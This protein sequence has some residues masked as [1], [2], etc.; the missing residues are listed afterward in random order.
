MGD[1]VVD[2][3]MGLPDEFARQV[4]AFGEWADGYIDEVNAFRSSWGFPVLPIPRLSSVFRLLIGDYPKADEKKSAELGEAWAEEAERAVEFLRDAQLALEAVT[5]SWNGGVAAPSLGMAFTDLAQAVNDYATTASSYAKGAYDFNTTVVMAKNVFQISLLILCYELIRAA[6]AVV[7]TMGGSLLTVPPAIVAARNGTRVAV[8]QALQRVS[9]IFIQQTLRRLGLRSGTVATQLGARTFAGAAARAAPQRVGGLLTNTVARQQSREVL[10]EVVAR[11]A[12]R[13]ATPA[14]RRQAVREVLSNPAVRQAIRQQLAAKLAGRSV[15]F[16]SAVTREHADLITAAVRRTAERRGAH[17]FTTGNLLRQRVI[18]YGLQSALKFGVGADVYAQLKTMAETD[19]RYEFDLRSTA[20]AFVGASLGGAPLGLASR[21]PAFVVLGAAGG[22]AGYAGAAAVIHA[23]EVWDT[24]T[25]PGKLRDAVTN[26]DQLWKNDGIRQQIADAALGGAVG[27]SWERFIGERSWHEAGQGLAVRDVI[28]TGQAPDLG[29]F[30]GSG[31]APAIAQLGQEPVAGATPEAG[32]AE[33][34]AGGT[35][36]GG[37]AAGAA[38]QS[39]AASGGPGQGGASG[40]GGSNTG[41]GGGARTGGGAAG[42]GGSGG[43]SGNGRSGTAAP[44]DDGGNEQNPESGKPKAGAQEQGEQARTS[45]QE[46]EQGR[47]AQQE[48]EQRRVSEQETR[49]GEQETEQGRTGD[50][51]ERGRTGA[52]EAEQVGNQEAERSGHQEGQ[53]SGDRGAEETGG[54]ERAAAE[55]GQ[56]G[57]ESTAEN[58]EAGR[59]ESEAR[60]PEAANNSAGQ[61]EGANQP[62]APEPTAGNADPSSTE[63]AEANGDGT[64]D[65]SG[66]TSS[67]AGRTAPDESGRSDGLRELG[68][69][70]QSEPLRLEPPSPPEDPI[71][72]PDLARAGVSDHLFDLIQ[73]GLG[74]LDVDAGIFTA[75]ATTGEVVQVRLGLHDDLPAG[76][77]RVLPGEFELTPAGHVQT[78]PA[79]IRISTTTTQY[80]AT[81]GE[82]GRHQ[83]A[84]AL[85]HLL[86]TT[87]VIASG[88]FTAAHGRTPLPAGETD[89]RAFVQPPPRTVRTAPG[90]PGTAQQSEQLLHEEIARRQ[91]ETTITIADSDPIAIA[92]TPGQTLLVHYAQAG[93]DVAVDLT[94]DPTLAPGEVQARAP[95]WRNDD[96]ST[97]RQ[98]GPGEVR[99]STAATPEQMRSMVEA[100]LRA[101]HQDVPVRDHN[102]RDDTPSDVALA[103]SAVVDEALPGM[104]EVARWL[105]DQG[106]RELTQDEL[107]QRLLAVFPGL[108]NANGQQLE[109][110]GALFSVGLTFGGAEHVAT[111]AVLGRR[112]TALVGLPE[113]SS[114]GSRSTTTS[115]KGKAPLGDLATG[116][117]FSATPQTTWSSTNSRG[118]A[119]AQQAHVSPTDQLRGEFLRYDLT[120]VKLWIRAEAGAATEV[121]AD[122]AVSIWVNAAHQRPAGDTVVFEGARRDEDELVRSSRLLDLDDAAQVVDAV[123]AQLPARIRDSDFVRAQVVDQVQR[124]AEAALRPD[125]LRFDVVAKPGGRAHQVTLR[126]RVQWDTAEPAHAAAAELGHGRVVAAYHSATG[127]TSLSRTSQ[128]GSSVGP[129]ILAAYEYLRGRGVSVGSDTGTG[130]FMLLDDHDFRPKHTYRVQVTTE[131]EVGRRAESVTGRGF[132]QLSVQ[133]AASNGL[134][135]GRRE[136]QYAEDGEIATTT[137]QELVVD[138]RGNAVTA[139]REVPLVARSGFT[140]PDVPGRPDRSQLQDSGPTL[141]DRVVRMTGLPAVR[142]FL[143]SALTAGKFTGVEAVLAQLTE[144]D[145]QAWIGEAMQDGFLIRVEPRNGD[146][147]WV[148]VEARWAPERAEEIGRIDRTQR[149]SSLL[150]STSHSSSVELTRSR[151]H[152]VTGLLGSGLGAN[153]SPSRSASSAFSQSENVGTRLE[154]RGGN[155]VWRLPVALAVSVVD[156]TGAPVLDAAGAPVRA[157]IADQVVEISVPTAVAVAGPT[158]PVVDP[159]QFAELVTSMHSLLHLDARGLDAA[160]RSAMPVTGAYVDTTNASAL[161]HIGEWLSHGELVRPHAPDGDVRGRAEITARPTGLRVLNRLTKVAAGP[162]ALSQAGHSFSA[163]RSRSGTGSS[164]DSSSVAE[165]DLGVGTSQDRTTATTA[166]QKRAGGSDENVITPYHDGLTFEADLDIAV[167]AGEAAGKQAPTTGTAVVPGRFQFVLSAQQVVEFYANGNE[168]VVDAVP[169]ATIDEMLTAWADDALPLDRRIAARAVLHRAAETGEINRR[170]VD[171]ALREYPSAMTRML[172]R[173]NEDALAELKRS[174]SRTDEELVLNYRFRPPGYQPGSG[175]GPGVVSGWQT[176]VPPL[177]QAMDLLAQLDVTDTAGLEER[178]R[179]ALAPGEALNHT[180][181]KA[182]VDGGTDLFSDLIRRN[183]RWMRLTVTYEVAPDGRATATGTEP[184]ATSSMGHR[185]RAGDSATSSTTNTGGRSQNL[186]ADHG[187]AEGDVGGTGTTNRGLSRTSSATSSHAEVSEPG[188]V[189]SSGLVRFERPARGRFTVKL[190]TAPLG[191]IGVV[192]ALLPGQ[193]QVASSESTGTL[194]FKYAMHRARPEAHGPR[195][196]ADHG[197]L[198]RL[199]DKVTSR[200]V[201]WS[202]HDLLPSAEAA[203]RKVLRAAWQRP[204][205]LPA[206]NNLTHAIQRD[207]TAQR[208]KALWH[209]LSSGLPTLVGTYPASPLHNVAVDVRLQNFEM[210]VV[211]RYERGE[212]GTYGLDRAQRTTSQSRGRSRTDSAGVVGDLPGD[213]IDGEV[214]LTPGVKRG[215]T[216]SGSAAEQSGAWAQSEA[217]DV[218]PHAL[219]RLRARFTVT[220]TLNERTDPALPVV[221]RHA[222]IDADPVDL[223]VEVPAEQLDALQNALRNEKAWQLTQDAQL[224]EGKLKGVLRALTRRNQAAEEQA[225]DLNAAMRAAEQRP[226]HDP[227]NPHRSLAAHV[228]EEHAE[229]TSPGAKLRLTDDATAAQ[230][231][232]DQ[233]TVERMHGFLDEISQAAPTVDVQP[234]RDVVAGLER[235]AAAVPPARAAVQQDPEARS[236]FENAVQNWRN[237]RQDLRAMLVQHEATGAERTWMARFDPGTPA[238]AG[239]LATILET[240]A[241]LTGRPWTLPAELDL[242]PLDPVELARGLAAELS[243]AETAAVEIELSVVGTDG[244][245]TGFR[246]T[247]DGGVHSISEPPPPPGPPPAPRWPTAPPRPSVPPQPEEPEEEPDEAEQRLAELGIA[248]HPDDGSAWTVRL[249]DGRRAVLRVVGGQLLAAPSLDA[250]TAVPLSRVPNGRRELDV[251]VGMALRKADDA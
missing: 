220:A 102:A 193:P 168:L 40:S 32:P 34:A 25:D 164:D 133:D 16:A 59:A 64:P 69:V 4:V 174:L 215:T 146:P 172:G 135:V 216:T 112:Q 223:Y 87:P 83:T 211:R 221:Q 195:E 44:G 12:A 95:G 218:N 214:P 207:F 203:V 233:R 200:I 108:F 88:E 162:M 78:A 70:A 8:V 31:A 89:V 43:G 173:T 74:S 119:M 47:A 7:F 192:R 234:L 1:G 148:K 6:V 30:T 182:L 9:G 137:V 51:T 245:T 118:T 246:I 53:R 58:Q 39:G 171:R 251:L 104:E 22:V 20:A 90:A 134:P 231:A 46:T 45:E 101:L 23:E 178:L 52:E 141:L 175:L 206:A 10:R 13:G 73:Q 5:G 60:S 170:L 189:D 77:F 21:L 109:L 91:T 227:Q 82:L 57:R 94:V 81:A 48:T 176:D 209:G 237:A 180:Q 228:R 154:Y 76:E 191:P 85:N 202:M 128:S 65:A 177:R 100:G 145:A 204:Q 166:N 138:G 131:I 144:E 242:T 250:T 80:P 226:D 152:G 35:A 110:R 201:E 2:T 124:R 222:G 127:S 66:T 167:Q 153:A 63:P 183:G 42:S 224:P 198:A 197:R 61:A 241:E 158:V 33:S 113:Q 240:A 54:Q 28:A 121:T 160:V 115:V 56:P 15:P 248:R 92:G 185:H 213:V 155:S 165:T 120:G 230:L 161:A 62:G 129:K 235:A 151:G 103:H 219:V 205:Q 11:A 41:H 106:V 149:V 232:H 169:A 71:R 132:A 181:G 249:P 19:G 130:H 37:T 239:Q 26:I 143:Q 210:Q 229:L 107:N 156:A 116:G 196:A 150:T 184:G 212:H 236:H 159:A 190:E 217:E 244:T 188:V 38:A 3:A 99:V 93:T 136:L 247:G 105:A 208:G 194:A 187:V 49:A 243:F 29:D 79:E 68:S 147:R 75:Q 17:A 225:V 199:P 72:M 114:S 186:T 125:G 142:D 123:L 97:L 98:T 140:A 179:S 67:E 111:D 36:T 24:V 122:R 96:T 14:L 117:T 157:E 50:Q 27:G 55:S 126:T 84:R 86:T 238:R 163:D 139:P 18:G